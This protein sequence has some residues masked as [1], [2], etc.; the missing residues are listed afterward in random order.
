MKNNIFPFE[1]SIQQS[2][3]HCLNGHR[4]ALVWFTGLSGSGKSTIA[5]SLEERFFNM[6]IRSYV[7]DGDN[8]RC[9]LNSD[10]GLSPK[11]RKENILRVAEVAKLMVD[12]GILVFATFIA[13]YR[14]SGC[15][16]GS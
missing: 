7:P 2:D 3:C 5:Y 9:G 4:S 12:S 10:L 8:I 6:G 14:E 11:D 15:L 16:P 13:P 1:G